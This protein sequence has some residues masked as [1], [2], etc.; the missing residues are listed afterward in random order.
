M[1]NIIDHLATP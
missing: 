1:Q